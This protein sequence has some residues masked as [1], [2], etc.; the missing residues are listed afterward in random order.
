MKDFIEKLA[1][2]KT[3]EAA[4][5]G[6]LIEHIEEAAKSYLRDNEFSSKLIGFWIADDFVKIFAYGETW[7]NEAIDIPF[8][9]FVDYEKALAGQKA[10]Y[11]KKQHQYL[12]DR[13]DRMKS[14]IEEI[15]KELEEKQKVIDAAA[16][17]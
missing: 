2:K 8:G 1:E 14:G 12:L 4:K 7:G 5:W 3:E 16:T 10:F 17:E 15:K 11:A 13:M 6:F 9:F